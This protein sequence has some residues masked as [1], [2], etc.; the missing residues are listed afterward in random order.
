MD[1][2][3]LLNS[4]PRATRA[5]LTRA[6]FPVRR[7]LAPVRPKAGQPPP[8]FT[9]IELLV[10]IAIIAILAGMLLPA[11]A[12]AKLKAT[13][14][15]C[16]SNEKQLSTAWMLYAHDNNDTLLP[17]SY[18][19]ALGQM[20]LVGG[21]F[22]LGPRPDIAPGIAV[23]EAERRVL[24][25]MKKSPLWTYCSALGAYHCPG[26][27][28][29]K[30]LKPGKGWAYDSYSKSETMFGG[31][32]GAGVT[33]VYQKLSNI[34]VP[35]NSF[36]FLEEADPRNYNAGTWV[37]NASPPGWVD[38]FAIFHG[39]TTTFGFADSHVETHKWV[40]PTTL[41][42]AKDFAK[43]LADF[44]WSGGDVRKNRDFVWI[45]DKYRWPDWKE[46]K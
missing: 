1:N 21:G 32:W 15:V 14:A 25:G 9:L 42:A 28:R 7:R 2:Y 26:D 5:P 23:N 8:G 34:K 27:L 43:G 31:G 22:W 39:D 38:G 45:Y 18:K 35:A 46:L 4:K 33:T 30:F 29:T 19:G 6:Q 16:R 11:L 17:T 12:K 44:Y 41:K 10:V 13:Q 3:R 40:E 36:V 20:D 24:E 37:L